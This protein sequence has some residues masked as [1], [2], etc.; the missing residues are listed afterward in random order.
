MD[1]QFDVVIAGSGPIGAST[2]YF[3]TKKT[4]LKVALVTQD[5]TDDSSATYTQAGGSLR[6]IWDDPEKTK[7]TSETAKFIKSLSAG[8][9]DFSLHE[10]HYLYLYTG[11]YHPALN[12][13]GKK[14]VDLL[15]GVA[16]TQGLS[17]IRQAKLSSLQVSQNNVTLETNAGKISGR[18][19]LLALGVANA[20][21][22][23]GYDL[24]REKRQLF[25]LDL[26]VTDN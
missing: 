3:L 24:D 17:I 16:G 9:A 4:S 8:G 12:F 2:A 20:E 22:M 19:V 13:S 23:P 21:F 15:L 18:K 25:V 1:T 26:P 7:M 5:P 10:D 11:A 14:L 6:W